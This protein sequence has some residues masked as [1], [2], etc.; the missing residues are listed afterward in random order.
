MSTISI[1]G[2]SDIAI[3]SDDIIAELSDQDLKASYLQPQTL[4]ESKNVLFEFLE[5]FYSHHNATIKKAG[6]GVI[7]CTERIPKKLELAG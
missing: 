5:K 3:P 7:Y 2:N 4:Y 6:R 1:N